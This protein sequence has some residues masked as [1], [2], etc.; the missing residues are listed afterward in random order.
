MTAKEIEKVEGHL[1]LARESAREYEERY[2]PEYE[3][4]L[5]SGGPEYKKEILRGR[6][7]KLLAEEMKHRAEARVAFFEALLGESFA[8]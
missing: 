1:A 2:L 3:E 5:K 7:F 4:V 8:E 6:M